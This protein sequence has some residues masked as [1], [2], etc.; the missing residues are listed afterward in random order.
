MHELSDSSTKRHWRDRSRLVDLDAGLVALADALRAREF[1][2]I[3]VPALGCSRGGLNWA[4]VEPRIHAAL[5]HIA[6]DVEVRVSPVR[7]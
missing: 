4:D 3:A 7:R 1:A 5:A 2:S 6:E